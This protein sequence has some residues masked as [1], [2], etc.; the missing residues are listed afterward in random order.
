MSQLSKRVNLD[1]PLAFH[2]RIYAAIQ[3]RNSEESRR[4]MLDHLADTK[5]LLTSTTK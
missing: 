3:E 4:Q 1:R 5:S 2:K